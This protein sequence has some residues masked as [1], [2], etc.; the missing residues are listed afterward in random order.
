VTGI[1]SRAPIVRRIAVEAD[2]LRMLPD[3]PKSRI[4]VGSVSVI[5]FLSGL[6]ARTLVAS[7]PP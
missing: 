2:V 3:R 7:P 1:V 5:I 6:S 4:G